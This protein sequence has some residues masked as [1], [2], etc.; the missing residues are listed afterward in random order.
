MVIVII[1]TGVHTSLCGT[2]VR[3]ENVPIGFVTVDSLI[4][5]K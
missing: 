3:L 5:L 1:T 4:T 2:D